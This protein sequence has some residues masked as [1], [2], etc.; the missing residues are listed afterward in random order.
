MKTVTMSQ[1]NSASGLEQVG[2]PEYGRGSL[3]GEV[4]ITTDEKMFP[5]TSEWPN[6][7]LRP[8]D[9]HLLRF[10]TEKRRHGDILLFEEVRVLA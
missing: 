7:G 5:P 9:G 4:Y 6:T 8:S 1:V 3:R 2:L 10:W